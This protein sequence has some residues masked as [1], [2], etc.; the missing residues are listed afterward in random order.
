MD[1]TVAQVSERCERKGGREEVW[2]CRRLICGKHCKIH[3]SLV[4]RGYTRAGEC[5]APRTVPFILPELALENLNFIDELG[6]LVEGGN[7]PTSGNTGFRNPAKEE[8]LPNHNVWGHEQGN[9]DP[10]WVS[11]SREPVPEETLWRTFVFYW[12]EVGFELWRQRAPSGQRILSTSQSVPKGCGCSTQSRTQKSLLKQ[13]NQKLQFLL[14]YLK[15][16]CGCVQVGRWGEQQNN[17]FLCVPNF[18]G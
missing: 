13:A 11:G 16:V 14:L 3:P 8:E 1:S 17:K 6:E 10:L 4:W 2:G 18:K 12:R 5:Y 7:G 9:Q 15:C